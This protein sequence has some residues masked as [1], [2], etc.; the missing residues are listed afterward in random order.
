MTASAEITML[1][2]SRRLG[3]HAFERIFALKG[4]YFAGLVPMLQ[5][6]LRS[7]SF[8]WI[9]RQAHLQKAVETAWTR[10][11]AIPF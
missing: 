11:S 10:L 2:R 3:I 4:S 1:I 7:P 6:Q 5:S 8:R 9:R